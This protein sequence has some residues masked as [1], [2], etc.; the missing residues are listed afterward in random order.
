M[1]FYSSVYSG[2]LIS[3]R[4]HVFVFVVVFEMTIQKILESFEI[5]KG[6]VS[7]CCI[8]TVAYSIFDHTL[9]FVDV[10]GFSHHNNT[11]VLVTLD[12]NKIW[13]FDDTFEVV[14]G[15]VF[16][17]LHGKNICVSS[18]KFVKVFS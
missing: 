13:I 12:N 6:G 16:G 5:L 7:S 1:C 17:S 3:C 11:R 2:R 4:K 9:Q 10:V 14:V 15:E 18:Q 8:Y